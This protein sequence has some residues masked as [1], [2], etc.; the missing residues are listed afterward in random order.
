MEHPDITRMNQTG[1]TS[2]AEDIVDV[3]ASCHKPFTR[4]AH[5]LQLAGRSFC[6]EECINDAVTNKPVSIGIE[7]VELD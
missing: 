7:K 2:R 4:G 5:V 3:C 6:D 1:R